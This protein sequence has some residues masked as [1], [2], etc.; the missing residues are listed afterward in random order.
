MKSEARSFG[1]CPAARAYRHD[2]YFVFGT[3]LV[4]YRGTNSGQR[5]YDV[6]EYCSSPSRG[7]R[8]PPQSHSEGVRCLG[9]TRSARPTSRPIEGLAPTVGSRTR[10][11]RFTRGWPWPEP[12][13]SWR[14]IPRPRN[15]FA[16]AKKF[17]KSPAHM[18]ERGIAM[19]F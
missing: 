5:L 9:R 11:N 17:G 7:P 14:Q 10:Q 12:C 8:D 16:L 19:T 13:S 15:L 6:R 3:F 18:P 1:S 2:H 4:S